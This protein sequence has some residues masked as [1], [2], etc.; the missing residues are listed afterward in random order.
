[1]HATTCSVNSLSH[2]SEANSPVSH[3]L[4]YNRGLN[5]TNWFYDS[6]KSQSN[7]CTYKL[8]ELSVT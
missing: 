1:M 7:H 8:T 6:A 3:P 4:T 2:N 5:F